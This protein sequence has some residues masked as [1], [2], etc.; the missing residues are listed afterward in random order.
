MTDKQCF[1]GDPNLGVLSG[2]TFGCVRRL[3]KSLTLLM[4]KIDDLRYSMAV[5]AGTVALDIIYEGLLLMVLST[6]MKK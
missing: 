2:F 3:P 1:C 5:A 4:T 6:M